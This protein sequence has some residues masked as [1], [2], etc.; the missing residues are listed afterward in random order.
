MT[1]PTTT[2]PSTPVT[3]YAWVILV[4]VYLASIAAPLNQL[5]VP[6][7][8][9]VLMDAL[10]LDLT[11][12][13][14][15]M[16][17]VA[18]VGVILALPAGILVQRYGSRLI[19]VIALGCIAAGSAMG[20]LSNSYGALLGSRVVEGIGISL[21][22]VVAPAT[23][24]L[25]F[26]PARQGA[27]M[28]IWSTWFPVGSVLMYLLAPILVDAFGWQ[29]VWWVGA[30]FALII[31]LVYGLLVRN[32]GSHPST[33][34]S[35]NVSLDF[36]K[37]L[38]NR[39]IWLLGLAFTC[40]NLVMLAINT[41]YPTFL[42][43]ERGYPLGQ[44][45]FISS[46]G[47]LI[48]IG[49]APLAGWISDRIGSRRLV[50]SLPFLALAILI[51]LPFRVSG[52]HIPALI[53]IQA[54][55]IGAIPTATFAAAPEIMHKTEWAGLGLAVIL[56]GQ[57]LGSL[58]GPVLFGG[59][60]SNLGWVMAGNLMVPVCLLGFASAWMVRIR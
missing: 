7:I 25:W 32:P 60:V 46:L 53:V 37:A 5:K 44:A 58:I 22:G 6:P 30:G 43:E 10:H 14:L 12:A 19:G 8:M 41:Y 50:F 54:M 23:I 20:A 26:P 13:G 34:S 15:L 59:L 49:S 28:G 24:A 52:W 57:Y 21:I 35:E 4:V 3:P 18:V 36:R 56:L 31:M 47:S 17:T 16:S 11:R 45:A 9:P 55:I 1:T 39:D 42:N 29:A 33:K 48:I 2:K 27:P 38:A 40:F 51:L